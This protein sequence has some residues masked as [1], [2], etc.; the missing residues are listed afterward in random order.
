MVM[1]VINATNKAGDFSSYIITSSPL[2]GLV[3]KGSKSSLPSLRTY[4]SILKPG[5]QTLKDQEKSYKSV[6]Q[7][8]SKDRSRISS[9]L[10]GVDSNWIHFEA[11]EAEDSGYFAP[12]TPSTL[13][14]PPPIISE[15]ASPYGL[16]YLEPSFL[17]GP[18]PH[19]LMFHKPHLNAHPFPPKP[20][21]DVISPE[22]LE[23]H[24]FKENTSSVL[25]STVSS[26]D[27]TKDPTESGRPLH[28][29]QIEKSNTINPS[30]V[31]H[32][33]TN[34]KSQLHF[35]DWVPNNQ[36]NE[37]VKTK[38]GA[39]R[40]TASFGGRKDQRRMKLPSKM[41][42]KNIRSPDYA[43]EVAFD[44]QNDMIPSIY[45]N[46]PAERPSCAKQNETFCDE[47]EEYPM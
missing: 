35:D 38:K 19:H 34:E 5:S 28:D 26:S 25:P 4:Y 9:I 22:N 45:L 1:Q 17:D 33:S 6:N 23:K 2:R 7:I 44:N 10:D 37:R 21:V 15:F 12:F 3:N 46:H 43:S 47:D 40:F 18:F 20:P 32:F 30:Q 42:G 13:H 31:N 8:S 11:D 41:S 29:H 36:R 14:P 24:R 16:P 39:K 27:N